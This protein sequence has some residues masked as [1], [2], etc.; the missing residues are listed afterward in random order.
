MTGLEDVAE[1]SPQTTTFLGTSSGS[2]PQHMLAV[3]RGAEVEEEERREEEAEDE[4]AEAEEGGRLG[5]A[6]EDSGFPLFSA[7]VSLEPGRL[8]E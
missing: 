3:E 5:A 7:A 4:L 8:S 2:V 6:A 1:K